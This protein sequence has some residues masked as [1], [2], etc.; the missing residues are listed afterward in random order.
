MTPLSSRIETE[1]A[2]SAIVDD[3]DFVACHAVTNGDRLACVDLA[4][5]RTSHLSRARPADREVHGL[6]REPVRPASGERVAILARNSID[7][8]VL[9]FA[10]VRAGTILQPLNWRLPGP[11]AARA[12]R[13]CRA[14]AVRLSDGIRSGGRDCC[15]RT[16][17]RARPQ[18][19]AGRQ[20]SGRRHRRGAGVPLARNRS[21]RAGHT[22]LHVGNDGTAEGRD[23]HAPQ[24]LDDGVQ[25]LDGER[26]RPARRAALRHA[27]VPC[28]RTVRR[29][30]LGA[31][32]GRHRA[33]LR[34]LHATG[35]ARAAVR[36]RAR[37]HP[38]LRGAADGG[39]DGAGSGLCLFRPVAA[40]GAGDRRCAAAQEP[41]RA[42]SRRRDHAGRGLWFERGRRGAEPAD[43]PRR[44]HARGRKL[45]R[46]GDA[47]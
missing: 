39:R 45:R 2:Y 11:G 16:R 17:H 12:C 29:V 24:C 10:C 22:A 33:D 13:R 42:A 5:R 19:R 30:A 6:S 27:D 26:C 14:C 4:Q 46:A 35:D 21:R 3:A 8:L 38:F 36:S 37:H 9:H 40:Q 23:R 18:N 47:D 41:G 7:I 31:V 43:R 28:R 25:L 1:A 15:A 32:H 34:P 20:P 44:D